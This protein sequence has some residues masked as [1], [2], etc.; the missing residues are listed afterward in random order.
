MHWLQHL[1]RQIHLNCWGILID[2][3]RKFLLLH[4]F[5]HLPSFPVA[6]IMPISPSNFFV[7]SRYK[8]FRI[9]VFS[10]HTTWIL[11]LVFRKCVVLASAFFSSCLFTPLHLWFGLFV[12]LFVCLLFLHSFF[13]ASLSTQIIS[14]CLVQ[15][16]VYPS[17]PPS[18]LASFVY[19]GFRHRS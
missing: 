13:H 2:S 3:V 11:K 7:L 17:L 16:S 1:H 15:H 14:A 18:Q 12:C 8:F 9:W 6:L 5:S 4:W 10:Y 19:S